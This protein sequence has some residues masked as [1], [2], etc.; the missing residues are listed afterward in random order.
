MT[1]RDDRRRWSALIVEDDLGQSELGA[2][3]LAE[4]DIDVQQVA[5]AEEAID[6]LCVGAGEVGI[7]LAEVNLS[8]RMSGIALA[9]RVAVLWPTVSMI[10]TSGDPAA[11]VAGLPEG[12]TFIPKPWRA[13][14]IVAVAE[15]AARADHSV[16]AVQL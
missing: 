5:S 4:L 3:M 10:V 14:D 16:R 13:L 2:M 6:R 15:R 8:G 7:V 12:A 1:R 9:C 11:D